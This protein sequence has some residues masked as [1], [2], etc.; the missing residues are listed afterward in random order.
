MVLVMEDGR[1]DFTRERT[2]GTTLKRLRRGK[3]VVGFVKSTVKKRQHAL[4]STDKLVGGVRASGTIMR[5][6]KRANRISATNTVTDT[7][8]GSGVTY[9]VRGMDAVL[10]LWDD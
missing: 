1:Q 9:R 2:R 5:T 7:M 4:Q 10:T 6:Y 8:T 3:A